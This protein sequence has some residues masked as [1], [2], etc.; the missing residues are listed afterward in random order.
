MAILNT[1]YFLA[2]VKLHGSLPSGRYSDPEILQVGSD[3]ML[4]QIVPLIISL[5][6]EFYVEKEDQAITQN[7]AE[8]PIPYRAMGLSLREIKKIQNNAI[9]DMPRISPQEI[10]STQSGCPAYFYLEGQNVVLYPTPD[11]TVDSLRLIYFKTPSVLVEITDCAIITAIDTVTGIITATP[12]TTWTTASTLDFVSKRNG[13]KNL[14]TDLIPLAISTTDITF[15]LTDIPATL[16]IGDYI[17][18]AGESP[19]LQIPDVCFDL[20]VRITAFELVASMGDQAGSQAL[21]TKIEQLKGS[22]VS[23]MTNRVQGAMK[24][25]TISLL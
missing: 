17:T 7:Q 9:I 19:Y 25:S 24:T 23:L 20:A 2:Q 15:T 8:Y 13:H 6:E 21:A 4:G 14:G 12:P 22:V 10:T 11:S 3:V 18:L 16:A 5:K 1:D